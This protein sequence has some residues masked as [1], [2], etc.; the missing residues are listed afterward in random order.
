METEA[1]ENNDIAIAVGRL[2]EVQSRTWP[3]INKP[4]GVARVTCVSREEEG[5]KITHVDVRYILGS[6]KEKQV[7][8]EY[9]ALAPQYEIYNQTKGGERSTLRDRSML[10]GRCRRCGSLRT[11]CGSCDWATEEQQQEKMAIQRRSRQARKK[12]D[13]HYDDSSSS[14]VGSSSSSSSSEEDVLL[15]ELLKQNQ[16]KYRRYLRN[17]MAFSKTFKL[18]QRKEKKKST[19]QESSYS[20]PEEDANTNNRYRDYLRNKAR[21]KRQQRVNKPKRRHH[22]SV[23][24]SLTTL[25]TTSSD[26]GT[27]PR[28][29]KKEHQQTQNKTS[30]DCGSP[31]SRKHSDGQSFPANSSLM[32]GAAVYSSSEDDDDAVFSEPRYDGDS[33]T[34]EEDLLHALPL[35][36]LESSLREDDKDDNMIALSQFIQP[37]GQEVAEKLPQDVVDQTSG[38][39][40]QELPRFFDTTAEKL[41]ELITDYK[42]AIARLTR[43]QR[44]LGLSFVTRKAI[45]DPSQLL[46]QCQEMFSNVRTELI[47]NGT[48][49]CRVALYKL[50][51]DRMYRKNRRSLSVKQRRLCRASGITEAR[52]LRLDALE[53]RVEDLVQTLKQ[54]AQKCQE[55]IADQE[56]DDEQLNVMAT[57]DNHED[58]TKPFEPIDQESPDK[59]DPPSPLFHP[60]MHA[61]RVK[62]T[63]TTVIVN[64]AKKRTIKT[65]SSTRN[66]KRSKSSSKNNSL[67]GITTTMRTMRKE[68]VGSHPTHIEMGIVENEDE[69]REEEDGKPQ[70]NVFLHTEASDEPSVATS[71]NVASNRATSGERR[72][73]YSSF[74]RRIRGGKENQVPTF[75]LF[76][77]ETNWQS[78]QIYSTGRKYHNHNRIPISQ[79]MQ[80][81]LDANYHNGDYY[82]TRTDKGKRLTRRWRNKPEMSKTTRQQVTHRNNRDVST[83]SAATDPKRWQRHEQHSSLSVPTY[84]DGASNRSAGPVELQEENDECETIATNFDKDNDV[85]VSNSTRIYPLSAEEVFAQFHHTTR[86]QSRSSNTGEQEHEPAPSTT[87]A[88]SKVC[89]QVKDDYPS[90][91]CSGLLKRLQGSLTSPENVSICLLTGLELLQ[92]HGESSLQELISSQDFHKLQ[93]HVQVLATSLLALDK[94]GSTTTFPVHHGMLENI[95]SNRQGFI[96]LLVLQLVDSVYAMLHPKAWSLNISKSSNQVLHMLCPLK[97][98]LERTIKTSLVEV[99]CKC[100][101]ERLESQQWRRGDNDKLFVSCLNSHIWK[102]YLDT[103]RIPPK[104]K[105]MYMLSLS[106]FSI[107]RNCSCLHFH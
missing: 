35:H 71:T 73:H 55:H 19:V 49:Q 69:M 29:S 56:E 4:G 17:K 3:G 67:S 10:L 12:N 106:S 43:C 74:S 81:F 70:R 58:Y 61:Q 26:D 66:K 21:W 85:F 68:I 107:E 23:L 51:D 62:K 14:E 101:I 99:A 32:V 5:E 96:D 2:V 54:V 75:D 47:R 89:L 1:S 11:D 37:E 59:Q 38:L 42:L 30:D 72:T 98:A 94:I 25:S 46:V 86:P 7:P 87:M 50:M 33:S 104:P 52:N 20:S 78:R 57:Q 6:S 28:P 103:G 93:T 105:G 53:D 77:L 18:S 15:E 100:I 48:D 90:P 40:Y 31:V 41:E 91:S 24:E 97:N 8:V 44:Q 84:E 79:R 34:N 36:S 76:S 22:A 92:Q 95:T 27:P 82:S 16:R 39:D 45:I 9:V 80:T 63:R 65:T 64:Q 83:A 102:D 60:H 88:I 13:D